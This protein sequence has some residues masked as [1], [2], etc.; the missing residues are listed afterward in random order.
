MSKGVIRE[1]FIEKL[2]DVLM[3]FT[4]VLNRFSVSEEEFSNSYYKKYK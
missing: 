2:S 1:H 4:D 3:Y